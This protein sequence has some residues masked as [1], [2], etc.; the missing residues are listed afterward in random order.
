MQSNTS[1]LSTWAFEFGICFSY[2]IC[3]EPIPVRIK[4][5][6]HS[7]MSLSP[8][9]PFELSDIVID[10]LHNDHDSLRNCSLVCRGW[11]AASRYH[12]FATARL[13]ARN[14]RKFVSISSSPYITIAPYI[15]ELDLFDGRLWISSLLPYIGQFV[16]VRKLVIRSS[17]CGNLSPDPLSKLFTSLSKINRLEIW[18]DFFHSLSALLNFIGRFPD[19]N[20]IG[21]Y[22]CGWDG[23]P[24]MYGNISNLVEEN[25]VL[26]VNTVEAPT[27]INSVSLH[28]PYTKLILRWLLAS[29][30]TPWTHLSLR[31]ARTAE[32]SGIEPILANI[33]SLV[34]LE[35][36][37][38]S[39]VCASLFLPSRSLLTRLN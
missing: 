6:A 12:H 4:S 15:R 7:H 35:V 25:E 21:I 28:M 31:A 19:L 34:R 23:M 18:N 36:G 39:A 14:G 11:I 10:F 26:E 37:T 1:L 17:G 29:S 8:P 20:T 24:S 33:N 5:D 13:N 27:R 16:S 32:L 22:H 2:N 3:L 38:P 30:G 9:F